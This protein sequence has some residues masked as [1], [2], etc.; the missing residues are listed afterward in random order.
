M[1]AR[2]QLARQIND[3]IKKKVG[4]KPLLRNTA[5]LPSPALAI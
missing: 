3:A 2:A 1:R 5:A 4:L